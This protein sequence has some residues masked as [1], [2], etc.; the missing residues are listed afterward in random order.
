MGMIMNE[1]LIRA[2]INGSLNDTEAHFVEQQML[3][4]E[5]WNDIY[6]GMLEADSAG[7]DIEQ[8]V[9]R[10]K[11]VFRNKYRQR[12]RAQNDWWRWAVA[13]ASL[14]AIISATYFG[15]NFLGGQMSDSTSAS[16]H[17]APGE[18]ADR[19]EII[20]INNDGKKRAVEKF[21]PAGNVYGS[22]DEEIVM[23][24]NSD[25]SGY[26]LAKK[27][28][29]SAGKEILLETKIDKTDLEL[30]GYREISFKHTV[31]DAGWLRERR[32]GPAAPTYSPPVQPQVRN[33]NDVVEVRMADVEPARTYEELGEITPGVEIQQG[34][35]SE[36]KAVGADR[37]TSGND[38]A[39][40]EVISAES[41]NETEDVKLTEGTPADARYAQKS[42]KKKALR[43]TSETTSPGMEETVAADEENI[44]NRS[45]PEPVMGN[46]Q[47][48]LYLKDALR[49]P[50]QAKVDKV[51]GTVTVDATINEAGEVSKLSIIK[52]LRNDCDAEALRL[53]RESG[54][55]LPA[56]KNGEAV[57]KQVRVK[58]KFKLD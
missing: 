1:Q 20:T 3:E 54:N 4:N 30:N 35:E 17:S 34:T 5:M 45:T 36:F 27:Q 52:S 56:V 23:D 18:D 38:R 58:V 49:Y 46:R 39:D 51:E 28:L 16:G 48:K 24:E 8:Q 31:S 26:V 25:G 42:E 21:D 37:N 12:K 9:E 7:V 47:F 43:K 6:E 13:A 55:W 33:Y 29:A 22:F 41:N 19:I 10:L 11:P 32:R 40:E 44:L 15:M 57:Q 50:E 14:A 2:Y 53:I